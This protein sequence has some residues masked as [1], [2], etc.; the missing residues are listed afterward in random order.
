[1]AG[2]NLHEQNTRRKCGPPDPWNILRPYDEAKQFKVRYGL[3]LI[4]V[5]DKKMKMNTQDYTTTLTVNATPQ[6]AFRAINQVSKW[7]TDDMEGDSQKLNDVF[8][9]RFFGGIHVSTQKLVEVV[10]GKKVVWL[11]TD[12][13]LNF[14]KDKHE[15]T[16]TKISFE[17]FEQDKKTKIRFTHLGLA[18]NV[19]CFDDCSNAWGEYL[20]HSLLDLIHTGKGHPTP[21]ETTVAEN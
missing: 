12:S 10:P 6:E 1:M 14:I 15:W 2:P 17:I 11:V 21:K 20:R 7:W 8:T 5:N 18:P 9:V 16:G 3:Y 4:Y 19:E 13:H